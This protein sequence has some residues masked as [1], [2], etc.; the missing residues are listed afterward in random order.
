MDQ[1]SQRRGL[2]V[3]KGW[4]QACLLVVLFGFFVLGILAYRTYQA[5]PPIP[6]VR[7]S[8]RR[9]SSSP[10]RT[11][12]AGQQV[13][14]RNGLMEYGSIFGHGAY[15]GPDFTAD[16][17]HRAALSVDEPVRRRR[18][19]T[20]PRSRRSPTSRPT[21]TTRT[22]TRSPTPP[23]R[24][25][26][27]AELE[28]H[29]ARLL[30][31]PDDARRAAAR[32]RSPTRRRSSELTAFFAWTAWAASAQRPGH[33]YSYTNNW[34][35]EPLVDNTPTADALV[36]SVLSL[37]AL[38]GGI[39][40][41]V[42]GLRPLELPRL[43]RP[44]A[45]HA[46]RS[47]RPATWRSHPR[48]APCAWFFLVMAAAVPGADAGRRRHRSTTAP[49]SRASS[50]STSR[51]VLPVQPR[52]HLAR[53]ARDLLGRRPRSWPPESSSRRSSPVASRAVSTCSPTACSARWRSSSS[54]AWSASSP[55]STAGSTTRHLV[56][57]PGLRVPRSRPA[58]AGAALVGL[59]FWVAILFRG[60]RGRLARRAH[61]QHA[62]A[63]L[64]RR[65]GDPGVLRRR[66]ARRTRA[67]TSP[68]PTSGASGSSTSGSRTSSSSSRR[69]WSPTSSCCSAWSRSGSR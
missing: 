56:R 15:L 30:R 62:V 6:A 4:L 16:Y 49:I 57:Q 1:P 29:Y 2:I 66:P 23:P 69:S 50:A 47:E 43:A 67:T 64:L 35:P 45:G 3:S 54:A 24:P 14:L 25:R 20:A 38:L 36:W 41:A 17:L 33:D 51:S 44:R 27:F 48:S 32:R 9:R 46:A 65:A 40:L 52:P 10:A 11:S 26:A 68:S 5:E 18:H 19:R 58:L 13:F 12:R 21:A 53:P 39:G 28:R 61:G 60:L 31:R 42:R 22:P 55:A 34:P 59:F 37:I 7:R 63:L 8:D